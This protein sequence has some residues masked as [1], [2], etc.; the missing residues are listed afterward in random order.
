MAA[1]EQ[2]WSERLIE[3]GIQQGML[4]GKRETVIRLARERFGTTP[5][6]LED[7]LDDL[8]EATLDG[9]LVRLIQVA[10]VD[11]LMADL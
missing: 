9:L 7:R 3:Q 6:G 11:E 5:A 4:R 2:T 8:D 10:S 1:V